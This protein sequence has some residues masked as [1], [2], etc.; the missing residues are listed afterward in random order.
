MMAPRDKVLSGIVEFCHLTGP[1]MKEEKERGKERKKEE[2]NKR[3]R[4]GVKG[5]KAPRFVGYSVRS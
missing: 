4:R 1:K 2:K 3:A 5:S